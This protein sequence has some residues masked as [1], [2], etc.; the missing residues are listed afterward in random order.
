LTKRNT[1]QTVGPEHA[2][3]GSDY[4]GGGFG[5][6]CASGVKRTETSAVKV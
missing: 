4:G 3:S 2:L 6:H 1:P 5:T